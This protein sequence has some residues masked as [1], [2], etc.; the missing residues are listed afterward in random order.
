MMLKEGRLRVPTKK[1]KPTGE[2]RLLRNYEPFPLRSVRSTL[3]KLF[4]TCI[5]PNHAFANYARRKSNVLLTM[6]NNR[7]I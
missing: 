4:K 3:S 2:G 1:I 5:Q 7:S 6:V